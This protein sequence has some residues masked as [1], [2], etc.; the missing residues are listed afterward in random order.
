M[1]TADFWGGMI[2]SAPNTSVSCYTNTSGGIQ[3]VR[4]WAVSLSLTAEQISGTVAQNAQ[5]SVKIDTTTIMHTWLQL[6][7]I[8]SGAI[9]K[10]LDFHGVSFSIANG[11]TIQLVNQTTA[12]SSVCSAEIVADIN[13]GA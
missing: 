7:G 12:S 5:A 4:V 6:A 8:D 3:V 10:Y 11:A 1:K 9:S 2:T 13:S